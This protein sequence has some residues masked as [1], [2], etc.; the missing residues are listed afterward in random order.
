MYPYEIIGSI[1]LYTIFISIGIILSLLIYRWC[2]D[3][4]QMSSRLFNFTLVSIVI[5]ILLG[6]FSA[7]FFQ[8]LYNIEKNGG[9]IIDKDTGATFAGGL[10]GGIAA[11]VLIYFAL[12][13]KFSSNHKKEFIKTLNCAACAI[14]VAH[15]MGRFGCLM[16]GCCY[17]K[18]TSSALGIYMISIDKKVI[19][20]Q[21]YEALFLIILSILLILLLFKSKIWTIP[22]YMAA[23]GTWRFLIEFL[24]DDFRGTSFIPFL[25]PS[26]TVSLFLII[27]ALILFFIYRNTELNKKS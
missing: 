2:A 12:G 11:F 15:A 24:R 4:Q 23:Y 8:A 20:T 18:E 5:S 10:I 21:L 1:D 13:K 3:K 22:V 14:P 6:F 19:P 26:Q 27:G 25:T 9:F 17:G 16:V 7:V